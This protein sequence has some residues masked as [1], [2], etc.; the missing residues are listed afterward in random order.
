MFIC[1]LFELKE[2]LG[3]FNAHSGGM[4]TVKM[5]VFG[6]DLTHIFLF[7]YFF[8]LKLHTLCSFGI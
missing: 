3:G 8:N 1:Y 4:L 2:E 6:E 7:I 5:F